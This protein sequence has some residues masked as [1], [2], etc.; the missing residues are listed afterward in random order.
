MILLCNLGTKSDTL[1]CF[2]NLS[3]KSAYAKDRGRLTFNGWGQY[4]EVK[5]QPIYEKMGTTKK[6]LAILEKL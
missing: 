5:K 6:Y 2:S 3:A 1:F 4:D